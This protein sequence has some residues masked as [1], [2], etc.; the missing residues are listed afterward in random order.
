MI[1]LDVHLSRD[2]KL[3]V[4]H[5]DDLTRCTD[6]RTRFPGRRSY[7]V[8]EFTWKELQRLDAGGWF[9]EQL[10]LPAADRQSF[11]QSLTGDELRRYVSGADR[12][13]YA[14]GGV[15]LP[16]LDD[17]LSL[18]QGAGLMV[19]IEIKTLPRMYPRIAEAVVKLVVRLDMASRVLISSFDHEQLL[20]VRHLNKEIATGVLTSDRLARPEE[21]LRLL[22]ADAYHPGCDGDYDSLGFHSV[23]GKLDARPIKRLRACGASVHVWT[24]NDKKQM[25]QLIQAG[26]TGIVTDYPNRLGDVLVALG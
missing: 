18:A 16:T 7:Q 10:D 13:H 9:V 26:A 11:L 23:K 5:D 6:V 2:G 25:Q 24:C 15:R 19:N 12:A 4:H 17:A 22:D 14:S 8:S 1:E 3:I 20:I 21:Y